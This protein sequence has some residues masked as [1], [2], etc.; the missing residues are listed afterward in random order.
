[1]HPFQKV[2]TAEAVGVGQNNTSITDK[3]LYPYHTYH[4]TET[5]QKLFDETTTQ[6]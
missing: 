3:K 6:S 1:M 4:I 2:S 5:T